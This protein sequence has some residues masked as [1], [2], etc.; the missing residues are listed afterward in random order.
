MKPNESNKM[1]FNSQNNL[2]DDITL[3]SRH[4]N[5]N[6]RHRYASPAYRGE[7]KVKRLLTSK[8]EVLLTEQTSRLARCCLADDKVKKPMT[9]QSWQPCDISQR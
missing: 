3:S 9:L 6:A 5:T 8:Q 1:T 2:L 7:G 4:T